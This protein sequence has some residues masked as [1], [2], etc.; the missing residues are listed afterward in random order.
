MFLAWLNFI[1]KLLVEEVP[2][3]DCNITEVESIVVLRK[4]TW[5]KLFPVKLLMVMLSVYVPGL[6]SNKTCPETP[7]LFRAFTAA[8]KEE[9]LP[10]APIV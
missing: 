1:T 7:W 5:Y 3:G 6:T 8:E 4:I 2:E 9:K 10:E